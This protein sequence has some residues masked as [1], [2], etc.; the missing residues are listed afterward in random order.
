MLYQPPIYTNRDYGSDICLHVIGCDR[1]EIPDHIK[2][3][4]QKVK[5]QVLIV[6]DILNA[7]L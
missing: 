4:T 2:E 1:F 7:V 6:K 5:K 3:T